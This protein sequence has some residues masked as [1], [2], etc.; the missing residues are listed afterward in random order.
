MSTGWSMLNSNDIAK[1]SADD[2][3]VLH[4]KV[5][6]LLAARAKHRSRGVDKLLSQLGLGHD[7]VVL[8][9]RRWPLAVQPGALPAR[10]RGS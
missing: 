2:Q 5:V 9:N 4:Q 8:P 3:W 7:G 6:D 1:L 10:E